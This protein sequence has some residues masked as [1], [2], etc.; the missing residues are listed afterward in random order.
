V[1]CSGILFYYLPVTPE[2]KAEQEARIMELL[3]E[4]GV[5]VVVL[6]RYMQILSPKFIDA[7]PNQI[8]NIHHSF[9]PAFAGADPYGQAYERGVKIIGA[10]AEDMQRIGREV[11]RRVLAQA[12]RWHIED[13]LMVDESRTV[14][15]Q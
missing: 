9:L 7:C 14:V 5:E 4:H 13:R 10:T 3:A 6:A 11:E 1:L 12:V 2:S 8:I 15:F